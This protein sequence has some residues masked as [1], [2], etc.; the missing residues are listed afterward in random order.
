M[1]RHGVVLRHKWWILGFLRFL[2][3]TFVEVW[4]G[5]ADWLESFLFECLLLLRAAD[6]GLQEVC[7]TINQVQYCVGTVGRATWSKLPSQKNCIF[8]LRE[9]IAEMLASTGF[10]TVHISK[11]VLSFLNSLPIGFSVIISIGGPVV[12]SCC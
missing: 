6:N 7:C 2:W 12:W 3:S 9:V 11:Y 10:G 4:L 8:L 5:T 1:H